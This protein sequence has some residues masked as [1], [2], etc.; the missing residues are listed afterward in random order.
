[1]LETTGFV[2]VCIPTERVSLGQLGRVVVKYLKDHPEEEH[3]AA[4]VLVVVALR[5]AFPC[6]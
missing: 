5:E 2:P 6:E 4:V 1:M 3:D